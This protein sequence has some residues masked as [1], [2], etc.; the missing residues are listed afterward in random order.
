M[1]FG[2]SGSIAERASPYRLVTEIRA[3][4]AGFDQENAS[5]GT[6]HLGT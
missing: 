1:A 3:I 6:W 4:R 5:L 2:V